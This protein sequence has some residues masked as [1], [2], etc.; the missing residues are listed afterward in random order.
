LKT[1]AIVRILPNNEELKSLFRKPEFKSWGKDYFFCLEIFV[2]KS[3]V[4]IKWVFG[5]IGDIE[6]EN[7]LQVVKTKWYETMKSFDIFKHRDVKLYNSKST[8]NYPGVCWVKLF[9]EDDFINEGIS[10]LDLFKKRF[11][12]VHHEIIQPWQKECLQK[13]KVLK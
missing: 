2:E 7:E 1:T 3:V 5:N 6:K 8:F 10:V 9:N 13:L 4:W 12:E 11:E